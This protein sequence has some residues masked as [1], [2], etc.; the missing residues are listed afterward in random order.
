MLNLGYCKGSMST[1]SYGGVSDQFP[2]GLRVLVVDDDPT[3]LE[4]LEKMLR[5]CL[6]EAS[7]PSPEIV[8]FVNS[9]AYTYVSFDLSGAE[10]RLPRRRSSISQTM[11]HPFKQRIRQEGVT[12]KVP[13]FHRS[14]YAQRLA[15]QTRN[16]L[17]GKIPNSITL[18]ENLGSLNLYSNALTGAIPDN[19][20]DLISLKNV[21]LGS[22][23]LSGAIPD[24]M[25]AILD[26]VYVDM[27]SKPKFFAEMKKLKYLNLENNEFPGVLP[28]NLTFMKRLDV[29]KSVETTICVTI[30]FRPFPSWLNSV[31]SQ[32]FCST[33]VPLAPFE[34]NCSASVKR[35]R[36][37]KISRPLSLPGGASLSFP[38]SRKPTQSGKDSQP[39]SF[40]Q[41]IRQMQANAVK[42][43]NLFLEEMVPPIDHRSHHPSEG[44]YPGGPR[45]AT[46][47]VQGFFVQLVQTEIL[48]GTSKDKHIALKHLSDIEKS[49]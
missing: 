37:F 15:P 8:A 49:R 19:F 21:S 3:C 33:A 17:K 30:D 11:N 18:L 44:K 14:H 20:G 5:I 42:S 28:F 31:A 35:I 2:A 27:S 26:L 12:M 45:I 9:F 4:I 38:R 1:A 34:L 32:T 48:H 41:L 13:H 16:S 25:S 7:S 39:Y 36:G 23:S 24:S 46:G 29:L 10:L 43:S 22:N 6:Y 47:S 40:P